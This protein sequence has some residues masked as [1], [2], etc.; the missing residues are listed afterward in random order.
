MSMCRSGAY[1]RAERISCVLTGSKPCA[2]LSAEE[3]SCGGTFRTL[4]FRA[5][6][7]SVLDTV[8]CGVPFFLMYSARGSIIPRLTFSP[9][10]DI[11]FSIAGLT[12]P[13]T[14][15]AVSC[16]EASST[17]YVWVKSPLFSLTYMVV[18]SMVPRPLLS[19]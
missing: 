13:D 16:G 15:S 19:N 3:N 5:D 18:I 8:S 4:L 17:F 14:G 9:L 12:G 7:V 2:T 11:L 1:S 10:L 6:V